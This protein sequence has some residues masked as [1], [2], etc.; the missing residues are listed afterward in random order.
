MMKM[1]RVLPL[2]ALAAGCITPDY[3]PVSFKPVDDTLVLVGAIDGSTLATFKKAIAENPGTKT[4]V[5]QN[6]AGSVDDVANL[7]FA[8]YV[9]QL[10]LTTVVPADGLVA[11][12]GTDL[13]LAGAERIVEDGACIGVHSWSALT[14]VATELPRS[15]PEHQRY[16]NYYDEMGI[17]QDFYWFTLEAAP[18]ESMHWMT[19]REMANYEMTTSKSGKTSQAE[20]CENRY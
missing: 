13:F 5:L 19:P 8:A 10:G 18:A 4:L 1:L 6:I 20:T 9:R 16:L 17:P 11:S 7:K 2:L 12:G 14:F 15:D 3:T